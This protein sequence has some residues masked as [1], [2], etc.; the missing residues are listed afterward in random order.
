MRCVNTGWIPEVNVRRLLQ[1]FPNYKCEFAL[2]R[3]RLV[4][5]HMF[6]GALNLGKK[7]NSVILILDL[8]TI[9][10][11]SQP[12]PLKRSPLTS[13]QRVMIYFSMDSRYFDQLL[14]DLIANTYN[15]LRNPLPPSFKCIINT[16]CLQIIKY[17]CTWCF[18]NSQLFCNI[19]D[20][21]S[22]GIDHSG[23]HYRKFFMT[24]CGEV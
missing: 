19:R 1:P 10:I 22:N 8:I 23:K 3:S 13:P 16:L 24:Q 2:Q 6:P 20:I 14:E 21:I 12:N 18:L 4:A 11:W 9:V 7:I 5:V 15:Q 17:I